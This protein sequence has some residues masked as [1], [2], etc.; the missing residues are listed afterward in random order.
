M[1][2]LSVLAFLDQNSLE[3]EKEK[4]PYTKEHSIQY[5]IIEC[6]QIRVEQWKDEISHQIQTE[7]RMDKEFLESNHTCVKCKHEDTY[8]DCKTC[9]KYH[10]N[11]QPKEFE[12]NNHV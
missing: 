5:N 1:D 6:L 7:E 3:L 8:T 12:G 10:T 9:G 2:N 11:W 4:P